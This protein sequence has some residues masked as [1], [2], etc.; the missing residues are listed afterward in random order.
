MVGP[1]K[2]VGRLLERQST[3][4][5]RRHLFGAQLRSTYLEHNCALYPEHNSDYG[6]IF[7][8]P[9]HQVEPKELRGLPDNLIGERFG[10]RGRLEVGGER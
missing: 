6:T 2:L 10:W 7:P 5:R 1:E 4:E 9:T 3:A 8:Q